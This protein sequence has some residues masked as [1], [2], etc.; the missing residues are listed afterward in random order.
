MSP[1]QKRPK[2]RGRKKSIHYWKLRTLAS[3]DF[4]VSRLT[5][6]QQVAFFTAQASTDGE[7]AQS[8]LASSP[9]R[10]DRMLLAEGQAGKSAKS[11]VQS[12]MSQKKKSNW[13]GSPS[14][15][16][17]HTAKQTVPSSPL[18]SRPVKASK[19]TKAEDSS[20][21]TDHF[22][23]ARNSF[24]AAENAIPDNDYDGEPVYESVRSADKNRKSERKMLV[25][26]V[27][28]T[29]TRISKAVRKDKR[30]HSRKP[31]ECITPSIPMPLNSGKTGVVESNIID[32]ECRNITASATSLGHRTP[33][34]LSTDSLSCPE[35]ALSQTSTT[36]P[37]RST[38]ISVSDLVHTTSSDARTFA[39]THVYAIYTAGMLPLEVQVAM[40]TAACDNIITQRRNFQN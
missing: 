36:R 20:S 39:P 28:V 11:A 29:D 37:V 6:R 35:E 15:L 4:D 12:P 26:S 30:S 31:Q 10:L 19:K 1:S 2:S 14:P 18:S 17:R 22:C 3:G 40:Y 34:L 25:N 24:D 13:D 8:T 23:D 7:G 5:V 32:V 16:Q 9:F 27:A 38:R 21:Q 33:F